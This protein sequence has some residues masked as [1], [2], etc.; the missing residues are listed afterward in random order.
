M[1]TI[2]LIWILYGSIGI[3][4]FIWETLE[5]GSTWHG[6]ASGILWPVLTLREMIKILVGLFR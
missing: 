4:T 5:V 6:I 1:V 3:V 2:E